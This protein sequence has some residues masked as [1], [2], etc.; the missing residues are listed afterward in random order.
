MTKKE[1]KKKLEE[2]KKKFMVELQKLQTKVRNL[3][4]DIQIHEKIIEAVDELI[5][6][7]E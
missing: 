5:E 2:R 6:E 4:V 1:Q 7:Y 3:V